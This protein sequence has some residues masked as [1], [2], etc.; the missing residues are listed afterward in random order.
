MRT[1]RL[2]LS[3]AGIGLFVT[4]LCI[5]HAMSAGGIVNIVA[6]A[7]AAAQ[8]GAKNMDPNDALLWGIAM[9]AVDAEAAAIRVNEVADRQAVL[10]RRVARLEAQL[11]ASKGEAQ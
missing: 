3:A 11:K 5:G 10:E 4:G 9:V 8:S 7:A 2:M 1:K 6:P